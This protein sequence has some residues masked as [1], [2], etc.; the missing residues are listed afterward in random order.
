MNTTTAKCG[1]SVPAVG[2]PGSYARR[3]QEKRHCG[4]DR[5]RSGLSQRFTNAECAAYCRLYD[6]DVRGWVV[7]LITKKVHCCDGVTYKSLIEFA[8]EKIQPA[9]LTPSNQKQ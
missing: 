3:E 9:A 6:F 5:C 8:K 7:D 2:A 1:C 4:K